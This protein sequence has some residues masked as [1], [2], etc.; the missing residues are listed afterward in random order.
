M[1][2]GVEFFATAEDEQLFLDYV[3]ASDTV[4]LFPWVA[5]DVA[6]PILVDR[7][8]L[9]PATLGQRYGIVDFSLGKICFVNE[10]PTTLAPG[11]ARAFALNLLNWDLV[12]PAAGH[13]LVDWNRTA[14]LFWER[15]A[16]T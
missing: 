1:A 4:R 9:P 11:S 8:Q 12:S 16:F 2:A 15:G 7:Q 3:L 10:R 6:N 14:A 5:M 13:G